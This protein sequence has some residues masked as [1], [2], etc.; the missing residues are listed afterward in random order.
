MCPKN[1]QTIPLQYS[2]S[3]DKHDVKDYNVSR[4]LIQK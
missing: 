2:I 3:L 1:A 4:L